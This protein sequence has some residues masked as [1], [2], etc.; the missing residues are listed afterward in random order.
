MALMFKIVFPSN[1]NSSYLQKRKH[2]DSGLRMLSSSL[3]SIMRLK[4]KSIMGV[5]DPKFLEPEP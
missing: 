3:N 1:L 4:V 5:L 2:F